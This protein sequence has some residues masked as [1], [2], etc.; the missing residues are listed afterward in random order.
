VGNA[1]GMS[2]P[3]LA[4]ATQ[5]D[6]AGLE[7]RINFGV[8]TGRDATPAELDALAQELLP[9]CG[10]A[11]VVAEVRHQVSEHSEVAVH[12]VRVE[13][14]SERLPESAAERDELT[15]RLVAICERWA[16]ERAAERHA[17][18]ADL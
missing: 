12:Q 3:P 5:P 16:A 9:E 4:F 18:I 15:Q 2:E 14:D 7:I 8:F 6:T 17:D 10:E 11:S 13:I 1:S